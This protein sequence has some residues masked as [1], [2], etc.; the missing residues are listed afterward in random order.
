MVVT[1]QQDA[2]TVITLSPNRS[3]TWRQTKWVIGLMVIFVMII[4]LAWTFVGAWIVLPFA[5]FE[6]GLFALLMYKVSRFTYS[7]QIITI[8]KDKVIVEMGVMKRLSRVEVPR[9]DTDFYY[10]ETENNWEL[11]KIAIC[12]KKSKLLIGDFLNLDDRE[13]LKEALESAGIIMLRNRWWQL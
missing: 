4:A 5:G 1:Q 11:P 2:Q 10:S 12:H 8:N 7:Q 3:A 6:V 9:F 13:I